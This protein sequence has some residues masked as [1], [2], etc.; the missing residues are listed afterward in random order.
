MRSHG[1]VQTSPPVMQAKLNQLDDEI[2]ESVTQAEVLGEQ[3]DVDAAQAAAA[4]TDRLKVCP[5][6]VDST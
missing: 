5:Q 2:Q 1:P 4:K 3:G 6:A